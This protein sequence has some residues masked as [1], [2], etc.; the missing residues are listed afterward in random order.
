MIERMYYL[1]SL[2]IYLFIFNWRIIALHYLLHCFFHTPTWIS[3]NGFAFSNEH[4]RIQK[5]Q[6]FLYWKILVSGRLESAKWEGHDTSI[7]PENAWKDVG[8]GWWLGKENLIQKS[9][10]TSNTWGCYV[11]VSFYWSILQ[12]AHQGPRG[13]SPMPSEGHIRLQWHVHRNHQAV[14]G[15]G[16]E[17]NAGSSY[18]VMWCNT[19]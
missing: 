2:F 16:S 18:T 9:W 6:C 12:I 3:H 5:P 14:S 4:D 19:F 17:G 10:S 1:V 13:K 7:R 8:V 15:I 11:T